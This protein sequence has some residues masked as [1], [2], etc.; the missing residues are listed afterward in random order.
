[1][2]KLFS[3]QTIIRGRIFSLD[4][5]NKEITMPITLPVL[6]APKN[7]PNPKTRGMHN[8]H[9]TNDPILE[10]DGH[11]QP[12]GVSGDETATD[13]ADHTKDQ[14]HEELSKVEIVGSVSEAATKLLD[15]TVNKL[16]HMPKDKQIVVIADK[17]D[18][19]TLIPLIKAEDR[20][21]GV[22]HNQNN[23]L[24]LFNRALE[25]HLDTL[26]IPHSNDMYKLLIMLGGK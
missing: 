18:V 16:T 24:P 7:E 23:H 9:R 4:D 17:D 12:G 10:R 14:P 21:F 26:G 1:M 5:L 13:A 20:K 2:R 8:Q 3:A 25:Q 11:L 19:K 22:F 6:K 15:D